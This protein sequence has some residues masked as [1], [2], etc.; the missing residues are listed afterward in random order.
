M[1]ADGAFEYIC[2][3]ASLREKPSVLKVMS[4]DGPRAA[5]VER[6]QRDVQKLECGSHPAEIARTPTFSLPT[7]FSLIT[8]SLRAS[9]AFQ[10]WPKRTVGGRCRAKS[11]CH[12][13]SNNVISNASLVAVPWQEH[14]NLRLL[15]IVAAC[16]GRWSTPMRGP[17][18]PDSPR[19]V[20]RC[21]AAAEF[22]Y[23]D[24]CYP[25]PVELGR[26]V[27]SG[28]IVKGHNREDRSL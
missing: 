23:R 4:G 27:R 11:A 13:S 21:A 8:L 10:A 6:R 26:P 2:T 1:E 15:D 5:N 12:H 28:E 9:G 20:H 7:S 22:K 19:P 25:S 17:M 24:P 18:S 3:P 14:H 16:R